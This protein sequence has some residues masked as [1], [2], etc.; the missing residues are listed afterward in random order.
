ME[1]SLEVECTSLAKPPAFSTLFDQVHL[2]VAL[3]TLRTLVAHFQTP[4]ILRSVYGFRSLLT[5]K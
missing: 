3:I 4:S 1:S 5:S 2:S